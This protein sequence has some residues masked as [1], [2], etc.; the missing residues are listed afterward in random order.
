MHPP[1]RFLEAGFLDAETKRID[2]RRAAKWPA[3][4]GESDTVWMGAADASGLVVSYIQSLYWEFGSGC[5]LP[6]K[7]QVP[8]EPE[9]PNTSPLLALR[10]ALGRWTK[11]TLVLF[12]DSDPIFSPRVA[13][14]LAE[15][16]PG[17]LPPEIVAGAGHFL[18]EDKGEEIGARIARFI[19]EC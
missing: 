3:P 19:A 15:H 10:D 12:S 7:E 5:V 9:H 13:E 11:P 8:T 18:Q 2:G 16:I 6:K 17:A 14:R 4:Y 1:S